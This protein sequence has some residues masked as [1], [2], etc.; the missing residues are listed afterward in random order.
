MEQPA[1][2]V[3]QPAKKNALPDSQAQAH[4]GR[5]VSLDQ[6]AQLLRVSR[7]TI[8]NHIRDGRLATIRTYGSQRVLVESLNALP[9]FNRRTLNNLV[10]GS[11]ACV[12]IVMASDASA[13]GRRP[14][15]SADLR[16]KVDAGDA[17]P[18]SVILTGNRATVDAVA[19]RHGL[20]IARRLATGAVLDVPAGALAGLA[21]DAGVDQLSS[22]HEVWSSMAVTNEA[23]GATLLQS[24]GLPQ[25]AGLTGK[26]IGVAVIDS[27]VARVPQLLGRVVASVDFTG[28]NTRDEYG[29]GTHVAGIIAAA[30][31]NP[32]G[33]DTQ[34][35][36]PGSHIVSLK[37]LDATGAGVAGNV[38]A[39]LDWVVANKAQF[40]IRVVNLSLG[41]P[42]LQSWRDDPLC[43]AVERAFRA[44]IL[45]VASAG[46][47]G[48]LADGSPV[49]GAITSPGNSPFALTVGALNTKG[50]AARS[51]DSVTTYS[52]KGP[53]RFDHL[54]KPD[55]VAPG[56][57]IVG[58]AAPGSTLVREHPE[59]VTSSRDGRRLSLSGTSMAAAVVSGAAAQLLQAMPTAAPVSLRAR[60][61]FGS[62]PMPGVGILTAG[63]G[64]LNVVG[65]LA[66]PRTGTVEVAGEATRFG[67][68]AMVPRVIADG[69]IRADG[70]IWAD[71]AIWAEDGLI[72]AD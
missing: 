8:Y 59:L 14:R 20:R 63:A 39:A 12:L 40:N 3:V 71:G 70:I 35:V 23:I 25:R 37:V 22:N 38:I 51:D 2:L 50:T 55:L 13:Q 72:W 66:A 44:G 67:S 9:S 69:T 15:L 46:N 60:L 58:L 33:Q 48:K 41:G 36:A 62:Q 11:L 19:A 1:A 5:S 42:V 16:H 30:D 53:T 57:K 34:G 7:R 28:S 56:N 10:A 17:T 49:F 61:Q 68:M 45:V 26:G 52:S 27:G 32:F 29:H 4:L 18:T 43:Q 6:A 64:S 24:T 31:V 65:A 47:K 54:V 21:T